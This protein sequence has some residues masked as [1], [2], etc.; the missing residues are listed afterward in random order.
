MYN[1]NRGVNVSF[2][3]MLK[4]VSK[5]FG[6]YGPRNLSIN[7]LF[8]Q[9]RFNFQKCRYLSSESLSRNYKLKKIR[10]DVSN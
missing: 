7:Y 10:I 6:S 5:Y 2:S 3:T 1:K 9:Y 4:D 8:N